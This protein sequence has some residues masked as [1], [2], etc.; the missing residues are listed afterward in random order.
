M[1]AVS[2]GCNPDPSSDLD[3]CMG[4][5]HEQGFIEKLTRM[6]PLKLSTWPACP[7]RC[8]ATLRRPRRT[9]RDS[10]AGELGAVIAD[11]HPRLSALC[12]HLGQLAHDTVPRI[13]VS[14]TAAR[15][16]LV[17]LSTTLST[18]NRLPEAIW[19]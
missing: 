3:P 19:S 10:I 15:H 8:N 17:T 14:G 4:K 2:P 9:L 5:A 6:R 13:D 18:R 12:D 16:S 1:R 11:D 7:E